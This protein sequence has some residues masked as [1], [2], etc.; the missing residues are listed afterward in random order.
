MQPTR[1]ENSTFDL[2]ARVSVEQP[3]EPLHEKD[4]VANS[5]YEFEVVDGTVIKI[6]ALASADVRRGAGNQS[7]SPEDKPHKGQTSATSELQPETE[8][9]T[10]K[11][12]SG[13]LP[14]DPDISGA[15]NTRK[16]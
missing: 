10:E 4:V 6:G 16:R 11:R 15:H 9:V 13:E 14:H 12:K 8:E 3:N 5:G 2:P 1:I 7:P